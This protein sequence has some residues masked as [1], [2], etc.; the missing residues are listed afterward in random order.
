MPGTVHWQQHSASNQGGQIDSSGAGATPGD[1]ALGVHEKPYA[2]TAPKRG[3][4]QSTPHAVIPRRRPGRGPFVV[5]GTLDTSDAHRRPR[6]AVGSLT[7]CYAN[8]GISPF[9]HTVG[10]GFITELR[11]EGLVCRPERIS[12][13]LRIVTVATKVIAVGTAHFQALA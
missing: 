6:A 7:S 12:L 9:V 13:D 10:R 1:A 8:C 2:A 11:S 4:S 3:K 5:A